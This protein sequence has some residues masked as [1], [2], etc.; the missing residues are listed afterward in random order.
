MK[1]IPDRSRIIALINQ[2]AARSRSSRGGRPVPGYMEGYFSRAPLDDLQHRK[3]QNLARLALSHLDLA[4]EWIR[5]HRKIR[6]F[7]PSLKQDGWECDNTVVQIVT[8]NTPFLIDSVTMELNRHGFTTHLVIHPL[9]DVN[10]SKTGKIQ[11]INTYSVGSDEKKLESYIHVEIDKETDAAALT[12]LKS[13]LDRILEDV[14]IAVVDWKSMV[15][16]VNDGITE[17]EKTAPPGISPEER[18][19]SVEFLR[20]LIR[21]HFTFLG[22]REYSFKANGASIRAVPDSGL[23]ILSK[24]RGKNQDHRFDRIPPAMRQSA[25]SRAGL[26]TITKSDT[27]A[28]IHRPVYLDYIGITRF[29]R[30]GKIKGE[31]RIYGL[32]TSYAYQSNPRLIPLVRK[33]IDQVINRTDFLPNSHAGKGLINIL[34]TFP[35]D[36]LLQASAEDLTHTALGILDL[37]ERQRVRVFVR[38]D[39]YERFIASLVFVPR[40]KFHSGIRQRIVSILRQAFQGTNVDFTIWITQSVYAQLYLVVHTRPGHVPEFNIEDIEKDIT[41]ATHTWV[42]DLHDR[43]VEIYDHEHGNDL[44]RRYCNAFTASYQED[45]TT[46][47][48]TQDIQ[49]I[50]AALADGRIKTRLY[51]DPGVRNDIIMFKLFSPE[52]TI[53]LSDALSIFENMGLFIT[54]E[55]PYEIH[56]DRNK[57]VWV[58]DFG[59]QTG[60]GTVSDIALIR[61]IFQQAFDQVWYGEIENDGFNRLVMKAGISA[62][63]VVLLRAYS[64]YIQQIGTAF[65]Q[66]YIQDTLCKNPDTVT[67]LTS[68]FEE[69]FD[70]LRET[71]RKKNVKKTEKLIEK[72]LDAIAS[73]DEDRIL[74]RFY[75]L[76][77][78][79]LRTNYYQQ[80]K[81][82]NRKAYVALKFDPRAIP[83]LVLPKPMFEIFVYS[84][85]VEGVHL[86]GGKVARGGI[87]WSD[88]REDFRTEILGLMKAQMVKNSIIVPVG[89]KGGFYVKQAPSTMDREAYRS[90]GVECYRTFIRGLLDLT[91]N[92]VGNRVIPPR[93]VVRYDVDDPYLVVAA[94]KG[95]AAFSPVANTIAEEYGF[96]LAD[97]FASGGV[98]G[99]DHK[100][101][102]ITAKGAWESVKHHFQI[103][104]L[105]TRST[106]FTVIGI[107]DMSGDVFGNGM[108]LSRHIRLVA[109]FNHMHIFLDPEP[110]AGISYAERKRLFTLPG[111]TWDDYNQTLISSGGG[112]FSRKLKS[113]PLSPEVQKFLHTDLDK[114]NPVELIRLILMAPVDLIWNGGIGTYIKA[115]NEL[116]SDVGDKANDSV[117]VNG[118]QLRCRVIGEGGNLG[119]TQK[120][121]IQYASNNG[122]VNAD[123]IDNSGGVACSD[124]EVNIK[125]LLNGL[126]RSGELTLKDR[127]RLLRD[128]TRDVTSLVLQDNFRQVRAI[129]STAH[130]SRERM[131]WYVELIDGLERKNFSREQEN[132]P[133][134]QELETRSGANSGLRRPE[135]AV[136]LSHTKTTIFQE[137]L[138]SDLP[139][140]PYLD[141]MLSRYFPHRL[142]EQYGK[143]IKGHQLRR[144]IVSTVLTNSMVNRAGIPFFHRLAAESGATIAEIARAYLVAREVY[145]IHGLYNHIDDLDYRLAVDVQCLLTFEI[146][147]LVRHAARWLLNNN[148]YLKNITGAIKQF[149]GDILVL[150]RLLR[151]LIKG[152]ERTMIN[153]YMRSYRELGVPIRISSQFAGLRTRLAALP[154]SDLARTRQMDFKTVAEHYF[155]LWSRLRFYEIRRWIED[156]ETKTIWEDRTRVAYIQELYRLARSLTSGVLD[157]KKGTR[158]AEA[159]LNA[160]AA[161]HANTLQKYDDTLEP[162]NMSGSSGLPPIAV[163]F[164]KLRGLERE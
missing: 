50:E 134:R 90:E 127:N 71:N 135:I 103:L 163:V 72:R 122:L 153:N 145:D 74:R 154:V 25:I 114:A 1:S 11:A 150:R 12:Q 121:R 30:T 31:R 91:D 110:D 149:S 5:G 117:R 21:N 51:R 47:E 68:L 46:T 85:R 144:E 118:S 97:A 59:M 147:H 56:P 84:P 142:G 83:D 58:Y 131:G 41:D 37:Q 124:R 22:Y 13:D 104:G 36:E 81:D 112:V 92:R 143:Q 161:L 138:E 89:A 93:D 14:R 29:S 82:G 57:T 77:N 164:D 152:P 28:T 132:I 119:I 159:S 88:R 148:H 55:R 49:L 100:K 107:G 9:L 98:A 27:L 101:M 87:R 69:R 80:S 34:E 94:D 3:P 2:Y 26:L 106:N 70:P 40:E 39:P 42:E 160:W 18:E 158:D 99:Y 73:L 33:K 67:V 86:R 8:R 61:E 66:L 10:R 146:Q 162:M 111:S 140:E 133:T 32:Y 24:R 38:C 62:R 43:L 116:N 79:T 17:I 96:W 23:G 95:T 125:I 19:E 44:Y 6:I 45:H 139:D 130:Q 108:L 151:S 141:G 109:A 129:T 35:R 126:V 4:G 76:I 113:I 63:Q 102:A 48:A 64:R 123:W 60:M 156:I 157:Y 115:D 78:A 53:P 105:D 155:A 15:E 136:L 120:G 128:M 16:K 54:T 7:N 75:H 52:A 137:I 65:S 20:W